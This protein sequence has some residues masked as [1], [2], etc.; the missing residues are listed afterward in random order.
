MN[1]FKKPECHIIFNE[2]K[3]RHRH[4][5]KD[6]TKTC[7]R[8]PTFFNGDDVSGKIEFINY[9]NPLSYS[10]INVE[11]IGLI[12]NYKDSKESVKFITLDKELSKNGNL[13]RETTYNFCF[14]KAKLLYESYKG[15]DVGVKYTIKVNI[16]RTI[17][18]ISYEEEFVVVN[19]NEESILKKNDE[20]ISMSVGIK[21]LLSVLIEFEH[22]NYGIHGTLKGF[23]TF[24]NANLLITKMEVQL[25][26]KE[27]IFGTKAQKKP[28]PK[29][30]ATFE[31]I[32]GGPYKNETI[33]FR[34]FLEP[35]HLTPSYIDISGYFSVRYYLN[36]VIKDHENNRY[37][38]QKE[39]FLHRLF[40]ENQSKSNTLKNSL[41]DTN[42]L[43]DYITEPIDYGDYFSVFND[44]DEDD[45]SNNKKKEL[46]PDDFY[47][48]SSLAGY[49][50]DGKNKKKRKKRK[51]RFINNM[52]SNASSEEARRNEPY[53][54]NN[55]NRSILNDNNYRNNYNNDYNN[56]DYNNNDY[57]NNDYNNNN[58]NN[59]DYNN[60]DYD[61]NNYNNNDQNYNDYNNNNYN[62]NINENEMLDDDNNMDNNDNNMINN[63]NNNNG[64]N[65][66]DINLKND[67]EDISAKINR[68]INENNNKLIY[69]NNNINE[70]EEEE[71]D[72]GENNNI[73][74]NDNND[75]NEKNK[76]KNKKKDDS[77][78]PKKEKKKKNQV[79]NV[80][81]TN[82]YKNND[83]LIN[84]NY[85][86]TD[87]YII[88][89]NSYHNIFDDKLKQSRIKDNKLSGK[90][91]FEDTKDEKEKEINL[92][93]EDDYNINANKDISN[94]NSINDYNLYYPN[95]PFSNTLIMS[96]FPSNYGE[97]SQSGNFRQNLMGSR[98]KKKK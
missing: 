10:S 29:I 12:E 40:V 93:N 53:F 51:Q 68:I 26:K 37:F 52:S 54:N 76:N 91:P 22:I 7:T 77:K 27:T 86:S 44:I 33:P 75:N 83:I 19:P 2:G 13:P 64:S 87:N 28:P 66:K 30:I 63:D 98:I 42:H 79:I 88:Y 18:N 9:S 36:L 96:N 14:N 74:N 92:L 35:Y 56:N 89:E 49:I 6:H 8:Y 16:V 43:K 62:N 31:L 55:Y 4:K 78:A 23:L 15:D 60:N 95:E 45:E 94:F 85:Y 21:D 81:E 48:K 25:I 1:I 59:N 61:N 57:N 82:K 47:Y 65:F 46:K 41:N 97:I 80:K 50:E 20:P 67:K 5:L 17:K 11:L 72:E 73:N 38:K 84:D 24:G 58:Y 32:D 71:E 69:G 39:I 34:F 70:Y 90:N 3:H